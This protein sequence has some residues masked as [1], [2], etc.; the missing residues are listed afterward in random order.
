[1]R[2]EIELLSGEEIKETVKGDLY[3]GWFRL[4]KQNRGIYTITNKRIVFVPTTLVSMGSNT[5]IHYNEIIQM[6][7]CTVACFLPFGI[8][9]CT[10]DGVKV[11]MSFLQR[12][13]MLELLRQYVNVV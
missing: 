12:K 13:K 1:M 9:V 4:A 3:Q 11:K 6:N 7:K 10:E 5:E 8:K 2:K